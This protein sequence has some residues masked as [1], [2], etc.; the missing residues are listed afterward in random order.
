MEKYFLGKKLVRIEK[1]KEKRIYA[2]IY[3]VY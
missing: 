3:D 2:L 1:K